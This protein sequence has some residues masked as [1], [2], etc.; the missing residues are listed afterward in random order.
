[1]AH[2]WRGELA[3]AD[4]L[5]TE[6]VAIARPRGHWLIACAALAY[7]SLIA[8]HAGGL[9]AQARL[10]EESS[11]IA[12]DH[13]L[14]NN[15]AGPSMALGVSLTAHR[16]PA[17][18]LPV[19]EHA[20]ALARFQAQP[21]LLV[22]TLSY[23]A[24]ALTMLAKH[25]QADAVA[26]EARAV[27]AACVDPAMTADRWM[28]PSHGQDLEIGTPTDRQ[29]THREFTVLTLLAGDRSEAEIGRELFVSHSTVHSHVKALYRKLGA[30]SRAEALKLARAAGFLPATTSLGSSRPR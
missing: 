3:D 29:L 25:D 17:E 18:A 14:E 24:D 5:Y 4:A 16:R 26:A 8:G 23:L 11:A 7:R 15:T 6:V 20:V 13:G 2:L 9:E 22:R 1:M 21:L 12:R 28:I 30:S 19:L 10:A 27:L